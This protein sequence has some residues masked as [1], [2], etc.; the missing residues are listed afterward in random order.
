MISVFENHFDPG[1]PMSEVGM[2]EEF[3]IAMNGP[4][5]A[6]VDSIVFEAM[7]RLFKNQSWHFFY[8]I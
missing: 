1:R 8:K 4:D 2:E 3:N 6:H 7:K 5:I